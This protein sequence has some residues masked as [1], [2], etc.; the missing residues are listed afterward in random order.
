MDKIAPRTQP[1]ISQAIL[2]A[3]V[4]ADLFGYPLTLDQVQKYLVGLVASKEEIVTALNG[5]PWL[6]EHVIWAPPYLM[7]KDSL[8]GIE[9]RLTRERASKQL[10]PQ[11]LHYASWI[12]SLP[13]V[14]MVAITGALAIGNPRDQSDDI[15]LMLVTDPGRVWLTRLWTVGITRLVKL[16]GVN[17]CPNYVLSLNALQLRERSLFTAHEQA[18]MQPVYGQEVYQKLVA[19]N[20]WTKD[21]L[22]NAF[23]PENDGRPTVQVH[24]R[25]KKIG[26]RLFG[27]KLGDALERWEYKRKAPKLSAEARAMGSTAACFDAERCKGHMHDY[28][29]RVSRALAKHLRRLGLDPDKDMANRRGE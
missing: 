21:F 12:A 10:W 29:A 3:L 19:A 24:R 16:W 9:N 27:G 13:F 14:R 1:P 7:L 8:G 25:L 11:A 17:L 4:Y 22:P 23:E 26:E 20:P 6:R 18:Q 28:G 2:R 5:D 15:D